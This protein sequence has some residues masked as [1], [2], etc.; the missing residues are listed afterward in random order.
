MRMCVHTHLHTRADLSHAQCGCKRPLRPPAHDFLHQRVRCSPAHTCATLASAGSRAAHAIK[1]LTQSDARTC[2]RT[3]SDFLVRLLCAGMQHSSRSLD[4]PRA[5]KSMGS[6]YPR[7]TS[8]S[9]KKGLKKKRSRK[10]RRRSIRGASRSSDSGSSSSSSS[11]GCS[12]DGGGGSSS[13]GGSSGSDSGRE[14]G[15]DYLDSPTLLQQLERLL[16][17]VRPASVA[18][19]ALGDAVEA[20]LQDMLTQVS[21]G[22]R[23]ACFRRTRSAWVQARGA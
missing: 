14:E 4:K 23:G 2:A 7:G 15:G 10:R 17:R 6:D 9:G 3:G 18:A 13:D 11:D 21:K 20:I 22:Q 5:S 1:Q 19:R 12:S 8:S 16:A